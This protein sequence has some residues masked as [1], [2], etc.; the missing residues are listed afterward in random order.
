MRWQRIQVSIII[1]ALI[2]GTKLPLSNM[3]DKTTAYLPMV[4][5]FKRLEKQLACR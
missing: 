3:S 5:A 2:C 1:P 4:E